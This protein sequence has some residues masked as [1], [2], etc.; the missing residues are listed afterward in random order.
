MAKPSC[1][2]FNLLPYTTVLAQ[3]TCKQQN[4]TIYKCLKVHQIQRAMSLRQE[5]WWDLSIRTQ[6]SYSQSEEVV[7]HHCC[8][9][10]ERGIPWLQHCNLCKHTAFCQTS[11]T[12][13]K[14]CG[15]AHKHPS[16]ESTILWPKTAGSKGCHLIL[17]SAKPVFK[18]TKY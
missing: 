11:S 10:I 4:D 1:P 12:R 14:A 3:R 13:P 8:V 7:L 5:L 16:S 9:Q 17:T 18:P 6:I 2:L 15:S